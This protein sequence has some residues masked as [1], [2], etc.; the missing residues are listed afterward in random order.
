[1]LSTHDIPELRI[2]RINGGDEEP[3]IMLEQDSCGNID[4]V[5]LHPVHL[6]FL[7]EKAGLL[8]SADQQSQQTIAAM[9]RRIETLFN[10]IDFMQ[11]YLCNYSDSKHADLTFE[12]TYAT[13]T[14]DIARE[15]MLES[16]IDPMSVS[17]EREPIANGT[18]KASTTT[19]AGGEQ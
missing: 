8:E 12:Q 7:A 4:R 6:R 19:R 18:A 11:S 15:F 13:A 1:M 2:E 17:G 3:L 10:R 16:G 5:A 9:K 14:L